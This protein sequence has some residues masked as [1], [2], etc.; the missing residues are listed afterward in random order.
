MLQISV[1]SFPVSICTSFLLL[2]CIPFVRCTI[3]IRHCTM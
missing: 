2:C 3:I 1:P